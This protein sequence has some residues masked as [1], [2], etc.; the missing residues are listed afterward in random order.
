MLTQSR[1][2]KPTAHGANRLSAMSY[3][4]ALKRVLNWNIREST[5][6]LNAVRVQSHQTLKGRLETKLDDSLLVT[7]QNSKKRPSRTL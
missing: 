3:L 7:P 4:T 2:R 1:T 5:K 6:E